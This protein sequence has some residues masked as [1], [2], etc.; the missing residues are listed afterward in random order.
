MV[1]ENF[2]TGTRIA[3]APLTCQILS[4]F[5]RWRSEDAL[6][7]EMKGYTAASLHKALLTLVKYSFLQRSDQ[8][9]NS[10]ERAMQ[11]W[12][13]WNPAAGFFH[14]S[15]KNFPYSADLAPLDRSLRQ[16]ALKHPLPPPVKRNPGAFH[17]ALPSAETDGEFAGVLLA[18]RTW[19]R[20]SNRPLELSTLGTLLG[21]TW[22][23][24]RWI[25]IPGIGKLALKTSPS[26]GALHPNE[27]Y[28]VARRV[29]G[30]APGL[31]HYEADRHQ[32][33]LLRR[34]ATSRQMSAYLAGQWW[35]GSAAALVI[36]TAV[37]RRTQWKYQ[38]PRAYRTVLAEAGHFCQTFCLVAV[39]L[40]LAP[41]CSM[42]LSESR[43]EKDL[44]ID[45]VT[46]GVV[47]AA[48]VGHP[49]PGQ[50]WETASQPEPRVMPKR[51]GGRG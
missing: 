43:I 30:L 35:F 16:F 12:E 41:F 20:F 45:G 40:G 2:A 26:G 47:Y 46:E 39:S 42:A 25:S 38:F 5:H 44:K 32:L 34:G 27:V 28:V 10:A 29:Q 13:S 4:F 3:A 22:G 19:R 6:F 1:F 48:G 8:K 7:R 33:A 14:F 24:Q 23:V 18:R 49:P 36:M 11:T 17:V 37:F 9:Q 51:R 50:D 21:L 15:T 31:Y